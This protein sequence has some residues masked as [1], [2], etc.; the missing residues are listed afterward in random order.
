[1]CAQAKTRRLYIQP[2]VV[3][4]WLEPLWMQWGP[5]PRAPVRWH[6]PHN[7]SACLC[8]LL[9]FLKPSITG[10]FLLSMV[11]MYFFASVNTLN[12][13][14]HELWYTNTL[15][16]VL[17]F[18]WSCEAL[19]APVIH[20]HDL[21][22]SCVKPHSWWS[23]QFLCPREDDQVVSSMSWLVTPLKFNHLILLLGD[24]TLLNYLSHTIMRCDSTSL[25]PWGNN[26]EKWRHL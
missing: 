8:V 6:H 20:C 24:L 21:N 1:M 7:E 3:K 9:S 13:L 22:T 23:A 10:L 16:L 17:L 2:S 26:M 12:S 25:H 4:W 5:R 18:S 11:L 14:V 15:A 19:K